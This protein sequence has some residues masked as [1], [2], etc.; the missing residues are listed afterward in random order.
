LDINLWISVLL[1]IPLAI[2]ANIYT[3]RVQYWLESRGQKR[4]KKRIQQL[5]V[6]LEELKDFYENPEKFHQYL[7]GVVI[8]ATYIGSIVGIFAGI[9]YVLSRF[10]REFIHI[11]FVNFIFS[12]SGQLVSMIGAMMIINVCS[13]AIRIITNMKNYPSVS[14]QLLSQISQDN[15]E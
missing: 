7:L 12:I 1:A 13:S 9:T 2:I 10:A 5:E 4:S 15:E 3:P 11:N 14:V 6:E 8:R